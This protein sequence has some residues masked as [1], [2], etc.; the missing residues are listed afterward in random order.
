MLKKVSMGGT[1]TLIFIFASQSVLALV[2]PVSLHPIGVNS[3]NINTS[4]SVSANGLSVNEAGRIP[5][6]EYHQ[7]GPKSSAWTR[8]FDQFRGDLEWLYNNDY[9]SVSM[10]DFVNQRISIPVGK[11]PVI[12]TF[13]DGGYTQLLIKNGK[14]DPYTAV[15]I[16]DD[17]AQKYPDFGTH[18]IFYI[19][20]KPFQL[21]EN[22]QAAFEYLVK[23]GREI[24]NHTID[25]SNLAKVNE[26]TGMSKIQ[27]LEDYVRRF[28]ISVEDA[29]MDTISYP[30]GGVPKLW[31]KSL[32]KKFRLGLLV[33]ADPTYV[34]YSPK[35]FPMYVPRIQAIDAEWKRWFK[36][37]PGATAAKSGSEIFTPFVSDG[38]PDT[39]TV[40]DGK[41]VDVKRLREGVQ[42]VVTGGVTNIKDKNGTKKTSYHD[43]PYGRLVASLMPELPPEKIDTK[44][45]DVNKNGV[46]KSVV[47][48][49][50][51]EL[52]ALEPKALEIKKPEPLPYE[53]C[54]DPEAASF[55][56]YKRTGFLSSAEK[57]VPFSWEEFASVPV[58]MTQWVRSIVM[59][60][61]FRGIYLTGATADRDVGKQLID[62]L[63]QAGGNTVVID[64]D[65]AA[66]ALKYGK[67]DANGASAA[68]E[69]FLKD[70]RAIVQYAHDKGLYVVAR[71]VALKDRLVLRAR[72]DLAI[73][74]SAGGVWRDNKGVLWLDATN[75]DTIQ[76]VIALAKDA[77]AQG[78]D[79]VQYDYIRFPTEGDLKSMR[80][81]NL[82]G[83]N[84]WQ[85]IRDFMKAS[86][87]E[88]IPF[89]V[90]I[91]ADIFGIVGWNNEYDAKS[92]GQKIECIAPYLDVIYPMGYPS[93]FGPGFAGHTNPADEPYYFI[94]KTSDYFVGYA[95]GT[96]VHIRPWLQS[97]RYRV[98]IPYNGDYIFQQMKAARDAGGDGFVLWNAG[99]GYD[100][101][102][103]VIGK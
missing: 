95:K 47:E 86:R 90:N 29:P 100:V 97:F 99:N 64:F 44:A 57:I 46:G 30:F 4:V 61:S 56:R 38:N 2:A 17:F 52:K 54:G 85:V 68:A 103:G 40:P 70:R 75:P 50:K 22:T 78:V 41:L 24:G 25:H 23:T 49:K 32:N 33:G 43:G 76:Y 73:R 26:K 11:K 18:A 84:F 16:M 101:A 72:S 88:L 69:P 62:R 66:G 8:S 59:N 39:V 7:V 94:K 12:F 63:V 82:N 45:S 91:G 37:V 13:D 48:P 31:T 35:Y 58:G 79:E 34:P 15:G 102:W 14:V 89:N 42:L 83:R 3:A 20:Q 6:M 87:K 1:L 51:A 67:K 60:K 93:H 71:I 81:K 9:R 21:T 27:Q 36:R 98:T 77:A 19:N 10:S 28:G 5:I 96:G 80:F 74:S 55:I 65:E 53:S 92:T